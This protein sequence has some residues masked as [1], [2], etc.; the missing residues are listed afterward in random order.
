MPETRAPQSESRVPSP[1]SPLLTVGELAERAGVSVRTL[2]RAIEALE[3]GRP[4]DT[5]ELFEGFD[6][7]DHAQYADEARGDGI[8]A[9]FSASVRANAARV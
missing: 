8:T 5:T 9:F 6:S 1:G 4:M 7:F 3:R 2:D